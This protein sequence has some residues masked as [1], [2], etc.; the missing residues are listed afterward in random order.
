[1]RGVALVTLRAAICV[2]PP[3]ITTACSNM[4]SASS[5]FMCLANRSYKNSS[6][7]HRVW[8]LCRSPGSV[9]FRLP[10]LDRHVYERAAPAVASQSPASPNPIQQAAVLCSPIFLVF[11]VLGF[12]AARDTCLWP[13]SC[14]WRDR[15]CGIPVRSRS[16]Q[17]R[18]LDKST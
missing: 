1:M 7:L 3:L 12:Q 8:Q 14:N 2:T 10:G 18:T 5:E 13:L 4:R 15:T 11:A 6:G 17:F 16:F 9:Q